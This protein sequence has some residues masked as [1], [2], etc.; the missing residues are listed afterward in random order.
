MADIIDVAGDVVAVCTE[1]A[2]RRIRRQVLPES[3][4]E[5]DGTHCVDCWEPL[6]QVRIAMGRVR[7]VTCQEELDQRRKTRIGWRE[8]DE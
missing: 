7:C 6:H 3:H 4:P 5:F 2:E 1:E 8:V